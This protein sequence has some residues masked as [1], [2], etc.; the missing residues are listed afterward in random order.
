M[1]KD[2]ALMLCNVATCVPSHMLNYIAVCFGAFITY[3]M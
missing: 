2:I 3:Y 1:L